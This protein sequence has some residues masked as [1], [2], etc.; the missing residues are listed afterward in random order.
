MSDVEALAQSC[1]GTHSLRRVEAE[2]RR[3]M[4]VQAFEACGGD[5]SAAARVLGISRQALLYILTTQRKV[6]R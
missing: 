4:V 5:V 1:V 6:A 3:A 2:V